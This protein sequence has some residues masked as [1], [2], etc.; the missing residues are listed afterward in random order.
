MDPEMK[1]A[2]SLQ[3]TTK[4]EIYVNG[5]AEVRGRVRNLW[6]NCYTWPHKSN[7]KKKCYGEKVFY[8]TYCIARTAT[9]SLYFIS[10]KHTLLLLYHNDFP[11]VSTARWQGIEQNIPVVI[12]LIVATGVGRRDLWPNETLEHD[13]AIKINLLHNLF[14]WNCHGIFCLL[15]LQWWMY[16]WNFFYCNEF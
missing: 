14:Y 8:Y 9:F 3:S 2:I 5:S 1:G 13:C 7:H 15:R 4:T 12:R 16:G 11:E 10:Q 6:S